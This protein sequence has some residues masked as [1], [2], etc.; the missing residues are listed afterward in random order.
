MLYKINRYRKQC[1]PHFLFTFIN[2][3]PRRNKHPITGAIMDG[4]G[5]NWENFNIVVTK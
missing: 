4:Y 3:I 5:Y 1:D 2:G